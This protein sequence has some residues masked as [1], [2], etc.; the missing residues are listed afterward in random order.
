MSPRKLTDSDKQEILELYRTPQETT[1]TLAERYQVSSSTISRFLKTHLPK[2]EY[3][4]LIQQKRL[5]RTPGGAAQVL[6]QFSQKQQGEEDQD[7]LLEEE[8]T[9]SFQRTRRRSSAST[10]PSLDALSER[11]APPSRSQTDYFDVEEEEDAEV[12][13]LE[14]IL[15]EDLGDIHLNEEEDLDDDDFE[16]EDLDD[17]D[18]EEEFG[19]ENWQE[20]ELEERLP[21]P[22]ARSAK[23]QVLP[24]SDASLPRICY[25]VIDRAAELVTPPL[26]E[27]GD[28]GKIPTDEIQHKTLPVFDNHRVAR[29]FSKRS[30]RVIKV[31]DGQMLAKTGACL[32]AKGIT[33]LLING[34]VYA[35]R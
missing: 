9:P 8:P 12:H 24:L 18:F 30:H 1:S 29:R 32:E 14:A 2:N 7:E 3:E 20:E 5:S 17:D 23:I 31:P 15:G 11:E 33:R 10:S 35:L 22:I 28:L 13:A 16:E 21:R 27:F 25:L 26:K 6:S 4:E 19:E 34:Q